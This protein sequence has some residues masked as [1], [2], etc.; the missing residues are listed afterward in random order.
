MDSFCKSNWRRIGEAVLLF[1]EDLHHT[2][3][4]AH[5]DI[6]AENVLFDRTSRQFYVADFELLMYP[7]TNTG[8]LREKMDDPHYFWYY[9]GFGAEP[10]EPFRSWR[11]DLVM[12]GYLLARLTW[13]PEY[14]WSAREQLLAYASSRTQRMEEDTIAALIEQRDQQLR[15]GAA[16]SVIAYMNRVAAAVPWGLKTPPEKALYRELRALFQ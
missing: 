2:H 8:P 16:L 10:D 13:N 11:M 4:L 1:L 9:L 6:K 14:G 3:G 15:S 7:A 5:L 12:L